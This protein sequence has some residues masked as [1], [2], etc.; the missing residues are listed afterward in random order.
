VICR[1]IAHTDTRSDWRG[2]TQRPRTVIDGLT[3]QNRGFVRHDKGLL[4]VAGMRVWM[5]ASVWRLGDS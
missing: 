2:R 4:F 5:R 3:T 1:D